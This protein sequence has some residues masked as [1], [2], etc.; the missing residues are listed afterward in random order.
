MTPQPSSPLTSA[1]LSEQLPALAQGVAEQF[2]LEGW[3][4]AGANIILGLPLEQWC[5][6]DGDTMEQGLAGLMRRT[7]NFYHQVKVREPLA[8]R[9]LG[10]AETSLRDGR[11]VLMGIG[12]GP[13]DERIQAALEQLRARRL[14]PED[15][16]TLHLLSIANPRMQGLW[17]RWPDGRGE[18]WVASAATA[19]PFQPLQHMTEAELL[20]RLR[21]DT[22]GALKAPTPFPA[23]APERLKIC[24]D[25]Q[26][27]V[28]TY[29]L[30]GLGK[31]KKVA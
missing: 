25:A 29:G 27:L 20:R 1:I 31:L 5:L 16:S 7:G 4:D 10:S 2:S 15:R 23:M 12:A 18:I 3:V 8:D 21:H 13:E 26:T 24:R 22:G 28:G 11:L 19:G 17:R 6:G 9:L 14:G 30:W